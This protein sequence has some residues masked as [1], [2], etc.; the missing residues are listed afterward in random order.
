MR[1]RK[2]SGAHP[3]D[4]LGKRYSDFPGNV[5]IEIPG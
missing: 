2:A 5:Q 3:E 1:D 4:G